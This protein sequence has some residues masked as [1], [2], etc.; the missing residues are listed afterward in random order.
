MW[1]ALLE[2]VELVEVSFL[3]ARGAVSGIAVLSVSPSIAKSNFSADDVC[4]SIVDDVDF[5]DIDV[6]DEELS[7]V[8]TPRSVVPN[9]VVFEPLLARC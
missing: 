2:L 1:I 6:S 4:K 7:C 5:G 3:A 8:D 9:D